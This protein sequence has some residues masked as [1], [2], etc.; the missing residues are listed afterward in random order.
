MEELGTFK[1]YVIVYNVTKAFGFIKPTHILGDKGEYVK[2]SQPMDDAFI[3][4]REIEEHSNGDGAPKLAIDEEVVFI[5][6]R[7]EGKGNKAFAL[8]VIS[9]SNLNEGVEVNY[10]RRDSRHGGRHSEKNDNDGNY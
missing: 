5:C 2:L 3:H 10:N 6:R 8:K 9:K 7:S 4:L 1:G